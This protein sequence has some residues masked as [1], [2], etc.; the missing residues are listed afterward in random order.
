MTSIWQRIRGRTEPELT[1]IELVE[2][3]TDYLEG[4]LDDEA[5]RALRAAHRR[6]RRLH[7]LPRR[8]CGVTIAVVGRIEDDDLSDEATYGAP[9]RVP[10]LGAQLTPLTVRHERRA[11]RRLR[12]RDAAAA[13][14]AFL[15]EAADAGGS[16]V[17]AGGSTPRHAYELAAATDGDWGGVDV[18]FGDDRCVPAD[19]PLSNQLLVREALL[20][21]LIVPPTVHPI[22]TDL[23]GRRRRRCLRRRP[24]GRAARPRPARPRPRRPHRLALPRLSRARR[25]RA[26]RRRD[27][28]GARAVRRAGDADDPGTRGRSA[29]RLPRRGRGQGGRRPAR[30]RRGAVEGHPREPRPLA[31]AAG[32]P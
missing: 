25:A 16:V 14:A 5:A 17:L 20:E 29:R 11:R 10:R 28:A 27:S 13:A 30:V 9:R 24:P 4:A 15:G 26:A 1:C 22:P 3:V 8:R 23:P 18:W 12:C 6:L 21:R 2:L 32:R 19:D 7:G 31:R